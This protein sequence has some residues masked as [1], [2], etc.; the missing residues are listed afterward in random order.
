MGGALRRRRGRR[1]DSS[2]D[3]QLSKQASFDWIGWSPEGSG[4]NEGEAEIREDRERT[5]ESSILGL[6]S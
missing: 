4:E 6:R 5:Q 1:Q 2:S 3:L